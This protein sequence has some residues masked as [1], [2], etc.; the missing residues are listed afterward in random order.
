MIHEA[1]T[2]RSNAIPEPQTDSAA[3]QAAF[4]SAQ[5][6]VGT[7]F[8]RALADEYL[9]DVPEERRKALASR[10]FS[11]AW[12]LGHGSYEEIEAHYVEITEYATSVGAAIYVPTATA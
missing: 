8:A 12:K 3:V 7:A 1:F 2:A 9:G 4:H 5:A 6:A 10:T 11:L